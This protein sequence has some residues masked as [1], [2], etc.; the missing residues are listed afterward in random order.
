MKNVYCFTDI[1]G[2][3]EL[4]KK[5]MNYCKSEDPTSTII[6]LG[7]ACD[8]GPDGYK[9][10]KELLDDPYVIYLKG[11]H[12]AIFVDAARAIINKY[13]K[14][15]ELY[16]YL[17]SLTR[18]RAEF[19]VKNFLNTEVMLHCSNGGLPTLIDWLVD[20]ASEEFVNKIDELPLTFKYENLDFCHAGGHPYTFEQV[21]AAEYE[22]KRNTLPP[23]AVQHVL[24][25]REGLTIGWTEGRTCVFGHTPVV[26]LPAVIYGRDKSLANVHPVKYTS[27]ISS[28]R[29]KFPGEKI[30]LDTAAAWSGKAWVLDCL[31]G[32]K[33]VEFKRD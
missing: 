25:D 29:K 1:H 21:Y 33:C 18:E 16:E 4:Y 31:N 2:M 30:D 9:I 20:G 24:W 15:E 5:I 17:H 3:Y 26:M 14:N 13:N 8:R 32:V 28:N 22:G 27:P 12:E 19:L 10:M 6:Y 11:N 7:D 23:Y